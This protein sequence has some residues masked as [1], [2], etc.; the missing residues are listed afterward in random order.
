MALSPP[1]VGTHRATDGRAPIEVIRP[2]ARSIPLY[3]VLNDPFRALQEWHQVTLPTTMADFLLG[4][5][6]AA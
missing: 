1:D 4:K 3:R 5:A 2:E 6:A